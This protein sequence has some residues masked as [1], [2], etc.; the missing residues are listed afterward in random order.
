MYAVE[1]EN[2]GHA[3]F[4]EIVMVASKV[5]ALPVFGVVVFGVE[6][7]IG[8]FIGKHRNGRQLAAQLIIAYHVNIVAYTLFDV[9]AIE[10][11]HH[12]D[13]EVGGSFFQR[14]HGMVGVIFAA[15]KA[16]FFATNGH[17]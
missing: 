9:Q 15:P 11:P 6:L 16:F 10:A 4:G 12:V 8:I 5:N 13:V 2:D 3:I 7:Q 14:K 1:I 17:K